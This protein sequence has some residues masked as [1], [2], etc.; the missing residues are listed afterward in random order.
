MS[1]LTGVQ[2]LL[3]YLAFLETVRVVFMLVAKF[4][5]YFVSRKKKM[6]KED[7]DD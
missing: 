5:P 2:S 6:K 4:K 3:V 1:D 7:K